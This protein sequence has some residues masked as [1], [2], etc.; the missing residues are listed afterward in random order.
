M[1]NRVPPEQL[2]LERVSGMDDRLATSAKDS[3]E[4]PT[5]LASYLV[6]GVVP[7]VQ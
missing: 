2:R 5:R 3:S 4:P 1:T 7:A 6:P